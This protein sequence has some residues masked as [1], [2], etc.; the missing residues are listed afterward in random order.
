MRYVAILPRW[1]RELYCQTT[2]FG[3]SVDRMRSVGDEVHTTDMQGCIRRYLTPNCAQL[4]DIRVLSGNTFLSL[5]HTKT[6]PSSHL[7]RATGLPVW[8]SVMLEW[9]YTT[10]HTLPR[11]LSTSTSGFDSSSG[12]VGFMVDEVALGWV[13]FEYLFPLSIYHSTKCAP[14]NNHPIIRRCVVSI[15]TASLNNQHEAI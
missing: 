14:F 12:Y 4:L 15:L 7:C 9:R 5:C 3:S 8:V 2:C 11:L 6:G 10:F 1:V 13:F